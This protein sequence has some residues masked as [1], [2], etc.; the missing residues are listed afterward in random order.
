MTIAR[1]LVLLL[2]IPI[3]VL[4]SLGGFIAYQLSGIEKQSRFVAELQI[5]SLAAVGNISRKVTDMRV[6][7]RNHLLAASAPE[8]T[9][10]A[11]TVRTDRDELPRLL[12]AYGDKLIS[13][14]TDR[15]L[16]TEFREL[17][18]E[19]AQQAERLIGLSEEG[20]QEEARAALFIG[21]M[22][23]LGD[24]LD[25]VLAAWI[26]HNQKLA[27]I[28]GNRA[29]R[30]IAESE[31]QLL[32]ATVLAVFLS[33][34]LGYITFRKIVYPIKGLQASVRSIADGDYAITVPYT[35]SFDETGELA[36]SIDVLKEGAAQT[37][38]QRWIKAHIAKITNTLQRTESL[39]DFGGRLLPNLIPL[40]G[41]GV[42]AFYVLEK[43]HQRLLRVATF[44]LAEA[45]NGAGTID[46]GQ[47][48]I[49]E[50]V[51][52]GVPITLTDLPPDYLRVTSG[53]GEARPAY[54][55]A[56]PLVAQSDILG[57]LEMASFRKLTATEEALVDE[58]L[59]LLAMSLQIV[60][61][62]IA[63]HQLLARTQEQAR[64]LEQQAVTI[65]VRA[66]LDAM[67]SELG[68]ALVRA[69]DLD[70]M[71]SSCATAVNTGANGAL[72]RI[73][74]LQPGT[75]ILSLRAGV[76]L[77]TNLDGAH[78]QLKINDS[79]LGGADFRQPFET[80][81]FQADHGSDTSWADDHGIVAL[82]RYPLLVQNR[83]V[84]VIVTLASQPFS[85]AEFKALAEA[86]RRLSV[87]IQRHLTEQELQR[88]NFLADSALELTKAGYW[89]VPL[90]GSGWYNSSER[91]V[92][93][94]GDHP[95]QDNRYR[96]EHW[97]EHIRLGDEEAA[98][99]AAASFKATAE[100]RTPIFDSVYAYKRPVDGRVVWIHSLGRVVK[101]QNGKPTDIYGVTQDISDFK[102]LEM[103]LVTA[104]EK[105]EEATAAKS[106]FLA[107]MSHEIRTPMNAIIGMTHLALKTDLTPK[108]RDYLVKARSAAGTL[109]GIINDILDFSKI[110]AGK[111]DIENADF[112]F[113]DVLENL[114]TVVGQKAHDKNL[115]F[116]ISSRSDIPPYL[117][118][119]PLRLG[120]VLINLVNNAV[121]FTERG[122]VI[123]T[124]T[125]EEHTE[126]RIKLLFSVKDTGIG[127]TKEQLSKLFQAFSQADTSTTRKFG[128]T[129]L[130]LSISKRLVEMMSGSI[131]AESEPGV[132]STFIFTA[133]F[134]IAAAK[135]ERAHLI[136]DLAGIRAL[137]VDD[138]AQAR[139]ILSDLLRGLA[140]RADAVG[141]GQEAV[142]A[143]RSADVNDPYHLVLM[144]WNMPEMDGLQATA[145]I[146]RDLNLKRVPRIAIVTAFGR[147]EIREK[148]EQLGVD[149][150]LTKPV[151][152]SVLYDAVIE[153]FG[154]GDSQ[155]RRGA[156]R[157]GESKEYSAHGLR[158][159]LVEDNEMNQQVATELLESAGATVRVADHGGIAVKIL[160]DGPE[161]P[162]F[163]VVLMDMQMPEVD[164]LT[165]TR[166]LR[167]EPRFSELPVIA[168]TA[169]ALVEER[170]RCLQA[171]M[172]DHLTKP[173]DPDAL[174]STLARWTKPLQ[175]ALPEPARVD[176]PPAAEPPLPNIE[177][178]DMMGGLAR[179]AGN[180]R[181]YRNLLDQ[182]A[183]KQFDV[184][185]KIDEA[186]SK[187]DRELAERL[188]H[189]VKGVAGNIGVRVVQEAAARV[190]R[191][192]R[193]IDPSINFYIGEL[194][195]ALG[196]QVALIR[197]ALPR[198]DAST[199]QA[200]TFDRQQM[201]AAVARLMKLIE[202]N[203][204]AAVDVVQEVAS[205]LSGIVAPVRLEELRNSMDEFDFDGA[206]T[207]L[208]Q[209]VE[210]YH[211]SNG[212]SIKAAPFA[213]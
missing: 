139:E 24:R 165:A 181:L 54:A 58:L 209:I 89:H 130:G 99:A 144:D 161:K 173:I 84:G 48:L 91:A 142:D 169:H 182:F 149:A 32:I 27:Q 100:G 74:I 30:A 152:A 69:K 108:Q 154:A 127:M 163:D 203:D 178:I 133:S 21:Y 22:P 83:L 37:T 206:R 143:V 162:E 96:L 109:L 153:L 95:T 138:N 92:R 180:K 73:W 195:G 122:E 50:C 113:E 172:N 118:G 41:G 137:V 51:R 199:G 111:L 201:I 26:S 79:E 194:N 8:R 49:G 33:G 55:I 2:A 124:A 145:L 166:I 141:S 157:T 66:R 88:I 205:A 38:E 71:L 86:A 52:H 13:D 43:E 4:I 197:N 80:N 202:A 78:S 63:T 192:V 56:Y 3:L 90:D 150:Y 62:N 19:W 60:L 94:F 42:A 147:E 174:F 17:S 105:A 68:A 65:R 177:G 40:L 5:E 75:D 102:L 110:E 70:E 185:D 20:R 12:A 59:P 123:V 148:A 85:E 28:A 155:T 193:E 36:R 151:N 171:G 14:D 128:G 61:R 134:G 204:G 77:E 9:K 6:N 131:R 67:H 184:A 64:Q 121:K 126:D 112:R 168:M 186:L 47:G 81:A 106:M 57:A 76:G 45:Q 158:I 164:G 18:S 146:R 29:V 136:P 213:T 125:V 87:G 53:L 119:D 93:I 200:A 44:G 117:V 103:Q 198:V 207:K 101:D 97:L 10:A 34:I 129:G 187:G 179:V 98:D 1:R 183:A 104:R 191:A 11:A 208:A 176:A 175:I 196:S 167:A 211:F 16:Y 72:T 170:E 25:R 160:R 188:A 156:S 35:E 190:E 82:A 39:A 212:Q 132:G 115:E 159:L 15:R 7:L 120:Q 107:N 31:R 210:E 189:T 116:L 135:P 23:E 140:L 114:S 46:I